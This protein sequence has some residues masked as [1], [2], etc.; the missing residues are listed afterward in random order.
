M[1]KY[2]WRVKT[3]L[4]ERYMTLCKVIVRGRMN[5]CLVEF[6]DGYRVV[7]SHNYLIKLETL[8]KRVA[9][10]ASNR[11]TNEQKKPTLE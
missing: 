8:Q 11:K 1:T 10:R 9:K 6:E 2:V 4:P 3:R 5:S 7:T